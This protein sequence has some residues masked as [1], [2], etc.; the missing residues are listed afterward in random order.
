MELINFFDEINQVLKWHLLPSNH[1]DN[2]PN[3]KF[4]EVRVS[5]SIPEKSFKEFD[6][7]FKKKY[8]HLDIKNFKFGYFDISISGNNNKYSPRV[9]KRGLRRY[10]NFGMKKNK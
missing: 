10:L 6:K 8:P 2:Y 3:C 4:G 1:L 7:E 9:K 5:I